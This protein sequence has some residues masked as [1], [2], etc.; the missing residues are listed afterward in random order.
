[1]VNV[2]IYSIHGSYGIGKIHGFS[3]SW[4]IVDRKSHRDF[5]STDFFW[6]CNSGVQFS[7][8]S[9]WDHGHPAFLR[10]KWCDF[11]LV[12]EVVLNDSGFCGFQNDDNIVC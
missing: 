5:T 11:H 12:Q 1:M 4:R 3:K 8:M 9:F 2:T 6:P 10:Q 7:S